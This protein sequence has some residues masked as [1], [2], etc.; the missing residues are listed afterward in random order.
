M[1]KRENIHIMRVPKAEERGKVIKTLFKKI[2]TKNVPKL[3]RDV[4]IQA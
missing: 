3:G 4:T 2:M 1:I